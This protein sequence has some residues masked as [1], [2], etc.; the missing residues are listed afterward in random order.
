MQKL[1]R[2][3]RFITPDMLASIRSLDLIELKP[4]DVVAVR[5]LTNTGKYCI[6]YGKL[7]KCYVRP[8]MNE[9]SPD[10]VKY[11][12][13]I[14]GA[15]RIALL[16]KKAFALMTW[17]E[18]L[19]DKIGKKQEITTAWTPKLGRSI[20][21][22]DEKTRLSVF[23][24]LDV[25]YFGRIGEASETRASNMIMKVR[26]HHCQVKGH[27]SHKPGKGELYVLSA[28]DKALVEERFD[29]MAVQNAGDAGAYGA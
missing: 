3:D 19:T 9:E 27:E 26:M 25:N 7:S 12:G 5:Y 18:P 20:G 1:N 21:E 24:R 22:G 6:W 15:D 23:K 8:G 13:L 2:C 11:R 4:E 29:Q 10:M 28:E 16:D 14:Y 17:F